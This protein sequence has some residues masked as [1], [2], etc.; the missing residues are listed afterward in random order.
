M[1]HCDDFFN[2]YEPIE[3]PEDSEADIYAVFHENEDWY[4]EQ[5]ETEEKEEGEE[6]HPHRLRTYTGGS[7]AQDGTGEEHA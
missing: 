6:G 1:E 2:E 4:G 7:P 5:T 3:L